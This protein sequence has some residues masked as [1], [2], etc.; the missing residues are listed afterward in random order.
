[1]NKNLVPALALGCDVSALLLLWP[2]LPDRL[3]VHWNLA[4][5]VDRLGSRWELVLLGPGLLLGLWLLLAW[6]GRIDPK[7]AR[8][9]PPD[10]PRAEA[11]ARDQV[12]AFVLGMFALFHV[13][14]L[15]KGAGIRLAGPTLFVLLLA[16]FQVGLGNVL[17][18]VRPNFFVGVRTPWTLSSDAVWRRTHRLAGKLLFVS[19]F[20]GA[21]AVAILPG[22]LGPATAFALFILALLVPTA[23]SYVWWK[24]TS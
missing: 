18:R 15:L 14:L 20:A 9:L 19:G 13:S 4:G 12:L 10:A 6:V 1:M 7:A 21:G 8:A 11:G 3:P 23:L 17:P 16:A 5:E 22:R 2:R 24:K